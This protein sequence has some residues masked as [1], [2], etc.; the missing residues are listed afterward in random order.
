MYLP[1]FSQD[2]NNLLNCKISEIK[3]KFESPVY[4]SQPLSFLEKLNLLC[5]HQPLSFLKITFLQKLG[6]YTLGPFNFGLNA[7]C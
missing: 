1:L 7:P 6:R 5:T 3:I 2:E 4:P